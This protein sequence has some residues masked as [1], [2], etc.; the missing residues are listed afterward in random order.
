MRK[1]VSFFCLI[2]HSFRFTQGALVPA[3]D[4]VAR[5]LAAGGV[6]NLDG[7]SASVTEA[8]AGGGGLLLLDVLVL[9]GSHDAG[10]D[11]VVNKLVLAG[12]GAGGGTLL[13]GLG[14][15]EDGRGIGIAALHRLLDG[16][17]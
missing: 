1:K 17:L 13:G 10:A 8:A 14:A 16:S 11:A 5:A 9:V 3:A 7:R 2:Q 12:P 4:D 6:V 15:A